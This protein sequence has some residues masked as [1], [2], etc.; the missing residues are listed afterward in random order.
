M[1]GYRDTQAEL[2]IDTLE[3]K[4]VEANAALRAREVELVELRAELDRVHGEHA[5]AA[6]RD[7][8]S[9]PLRILGG[10]LML[11]MIAS[12]VGAR[13]LRARATCGSSQA[14]EEIARLR[15]ELEMERGENEA[16]RALPP[17]IQAIPPVPAGALAADPANETGVHR[18]FDRAAAAKIL[19]A[20]AAGVK[21]CNAPGGVGRT[22][23]IQIT[24]EPSGAVRSAVLQD[25]SLAQTRAGACVAARFRDLHIPA[26]DGGP[27][28]VSKS[29][30]VDANIY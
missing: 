27:V 3:A 17:S 25:P 9:G 28:T 13:A 7:A 15:A 23:K 1:A 19:A 11:A 20:A 30:S 12:M 14:Q 6:P 18:D 5:V 22:T 4:L 16:L 24:F 29:F 8:T 10:A 21:S 26:F 2:R